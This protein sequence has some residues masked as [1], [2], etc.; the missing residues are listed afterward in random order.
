MNRYPA[1]KTQTLS[2]RIDKN[3]FITTPSDEPFDISDEQ[4][5]QIIALL[6]KQ[7]LSFFGFAPQ[8]EYGT[9][10]TRKLEISFRILLRHNLPQLQK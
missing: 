5:T 7:C 2:I 6:R 8:Y 4:Y 1:Q 9:T 10:N 3:I